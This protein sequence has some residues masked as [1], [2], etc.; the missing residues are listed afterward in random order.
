MKPMNRREAVKATT[1]LVGGF[2]VSYSGLLTACA[3]DAGKQSGQVL[4]ADDQSL[5][6]AI[7]DTILPTTAS[8]PGAKAAGAGP[9]MNL[10]LTD[11]YKADAQKRV[12]DG[13]E[14]FRAKCKDNCGGDFASLAPAKREAFV[15]EI[16]SEAMKAPDHHYFP[17]VSELSRNAYFT[18]Q[19][20]L[21]KALRYEQTPGKWIGCVPLQPGQPAWG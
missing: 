17:I 15:R 10:L 2:W 16:A 3:P 21:T 20:G 9:V 12:V 5:M 19:I 4:S 14:E 7:A 13:L 18:S 1:L 8:S 11:C 6:E